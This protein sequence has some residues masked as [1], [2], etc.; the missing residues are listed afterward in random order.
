MSVLTA[1]QAVFDFIKKST[2]NDVLA[3]KERKDELICTDLNTSLEEALSIMK[4]NDIT[5]LVVRD[6][7]GKLASV[8]DVIDIINFVIF[9]PYL[10]YVTQNEVSFEKYHF[11]GETIETL[12]KN[13]KIAKEVFLAPADTALVD[14]IPFFGPNG[15][16]YRG[17]AFNREG[18]NYLFSQSDIVKFLFENEDKLGDIK[19]TRIEDLN[20]ANPLGKPL[21]Q[22]NAD[23]AAF[24]GFLQIATEN[25]HAI[26]IVDN[27][28]KIVGTLSA[29][30]LRGLTSEGLPNLN[31]PVYQYCK[32]I[33][34]GFVPVTVTS[35]T[36]LGEVL[37]KLVRSKPRIHRV[38]I[39]NSSQEPIGVVTLTD[40]LGLFEVQVPPS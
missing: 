4:K 35:R 17:V 5:S 26:A 24:Q 12:L 13:R 14:I 38:W 9:D 32:D 16:H 27:E 37:L 20:L 23:E 34:G 28:G 29:S 31:K 15:K 22:I 2:I 6:A 19:D 18:K 1:K 25:I 39:I 36:Q 40:I 3:T 30:D 8:V 21:R 7:Q 10:S 33:G 11:S